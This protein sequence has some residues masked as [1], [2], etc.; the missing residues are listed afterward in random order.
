VTVTEE[1]IIVSIGVVV[2]ALCVLYGVLRW[3]GV[4]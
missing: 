4:L 2:M 1:T 3:K